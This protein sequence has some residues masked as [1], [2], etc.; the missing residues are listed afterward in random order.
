MNGIGNLYGG[1]V[2]SATRPAFDYSSDLVFTIPTGDRARGFSTGRVTADWTNTFSKTFSIITPYVSVGAANSISDTS[3]FVRP[4][5]SSG[6]VGHFE[7]GSLMNVSALIDV[8]VSTYSVR[9]AGEQEI[10]SRVVDKP[11]AQSESQQSGGAVSS[12]VRGIG[13]A[14]RS[15]PA[16]A[17]ETQRETFGTAEIANDHGFSTRLTV[18]PTSGT[19]LQIGYSRSVAYRFDTLFF[20]VGFRT[21]H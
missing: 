14:R 10:L 11:A 8:G 5:S 15:E 2:F 9:A 1:V 16:P 6:M 19:D 4:F 21:R 3:F 17:F 12:V 7:G 18:R 20:G 13:L